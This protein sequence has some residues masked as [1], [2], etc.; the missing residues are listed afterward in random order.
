M[1]RA[2]VP[3]AEFRACL[4]LGFRHVTATNSNASPRQRRKPE[5]PRGLRRSMRPLSGTGMVYEL[6]SRPYC[7]RSAEH[8]RRLVAL[9]IN[10]SAYFE[11]DARRSAVR[12]SADVS[13]F[14]FEVR[15]S[16]EEA[17]ASRKRA[18]SR[19]TGAPRSGQ[20]SARI[21]HVDLQRGRWWRG[22]TDVPFRPARPPQRRGG[23]FHQTISRVSGAAPFTAAGFTSAPS[24]SRHEVH[25]WPVTYNRRRATTATTC[26]VAPL[27]RSSTTTSESKAA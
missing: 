26:A 11:A 6:P 4:A 12:R 10:I 15:L 2:S 1:S 21:Q 27:K 20:G 25:A 23:R 16:A 5:R 17:R 13:S 14:A 3:S 18:S 24:A 7:R 22:P 19:T 8:E 9:P